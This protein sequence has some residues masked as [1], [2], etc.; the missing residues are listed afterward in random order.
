VADLLPE[1][2]N[3]I[4]VSPKPRRAAAEAVEATKT[5]SVR[6][7]GAEPRS[8]GDRHGALRKA[9][10]GAKALRGLWETADD[11]TKEWFVDAVLFEL[12]E[13]GAARWN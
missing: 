5:A 3:A 13:D 12:D 1:Q 8:D 6:V 10:Q 4:A 11:R 7:G 2:Q 9:W